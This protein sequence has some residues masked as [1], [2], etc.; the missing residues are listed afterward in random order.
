MLTQIKPDVLL[1]KN[2]SEETR[3]EFI[4]LKVTNKIAKMGKDARWVFENFDK[5]H[6]GHCKLSVF[7]TL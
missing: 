2:V 1:E 5:D 3:I 7:I 4:I 6:S